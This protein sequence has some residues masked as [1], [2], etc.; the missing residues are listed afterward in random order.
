MRKKSVYP[1]WALLPALLIFTLFAVVPLIG[2]LIFSFSD[3]NISRFY[4][5][6]FRGITNYISLLSDSVFLHSL[7]NT[8]LFAVC[9][10][11]L[12][13]AAGLA[14]ALLLVRRIPANNLLRTVFY[15]PCVLS[16]T[17]VGVL[18]KAILSKTGLLNNALTA[19]GIM[20]TTD[21]LAHY[22]TAMG[23]VVLIESWM[24]AGFNMFIFISGL[25][26]VPK[27][28]YEYASIEGAS[29]REKFRYVTLPL[30]VPSFTVVITLG[31]SG[32]L[33][34]FDIIYVI[35][36]G[37]PGFDT[38]V[39]STYVYQSF[40]LGYLGESAAGS[41]I[42]CL[43]VTLVSFLLNKLLVNKEVEA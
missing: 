40:S 27:D 30:I 7:W 24:W 3:W 21:W 37:G 32:G 17:V 12:K 20:S 15:A 41:V 26:A 10:T 4:T 18:F 2:S 35:T 39:L 25:Q 9:T 31:I 23:A 11:A 8:F 6:Q 5:P 29:A 42:L 34:V 14:L 1:Y 28:Y 13:T 36:N 16:V 38:Q 22:G 43:I 33:K 19:I